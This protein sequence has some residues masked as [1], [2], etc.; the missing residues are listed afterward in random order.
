[1]DCLA[2]RATFREILRVPGWRFMRSKN[3]HPLCLRKEN[4]D[5]LWEYTRGDAR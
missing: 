2:K 4:I 5:S 3:Y 1:V